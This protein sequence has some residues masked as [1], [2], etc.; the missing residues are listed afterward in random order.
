MKRMVAALVVMG[1]WA[2]NNAASPETTN[3]DQ[4]H[5]ADSG[6]TPGG[7]ATPADTAGNRAAIDSVQLD[8]LNR[9]TNR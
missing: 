6:A 8:T 3:V 1:L 4:T 7:S 9:Q 5:N 2:C